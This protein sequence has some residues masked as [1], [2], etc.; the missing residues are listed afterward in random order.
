M[1]LFLTT[2]RQNKFSKKYL[3]VNLNLLKQ[4]FSFGDLNSQKNML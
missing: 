3:I 4:R 2:K 1:F